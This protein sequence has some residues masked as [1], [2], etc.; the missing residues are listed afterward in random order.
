MNKL[1]VGDV[2][3][4]FE[5]DSTEGLVSL[6]KLENKMVV[7]Y[8]YPKDM[9]PGCTIQAQEFSCLYKEF[10]KLDVLV[11]G[12]SKDSLDT[13]HRF[14]TKAN[15]KY[16]LLVNID[17]EI[18]NLY[19]TLKEKSTFGKNYFGIVRATFLIGKD[20]KLLKIWN[21]IKPQGHAQ[22]VLDQV[23]ISKMLQKSGF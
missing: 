13:H 8:F 16:P 4:D 14:C 20:R 17:N 11:L 10:K 18:P 5:A 21:N 6:S 23:N 3:P 2:A 7:L 15:I 12:I 1:Q 22:K 19:G 9:T